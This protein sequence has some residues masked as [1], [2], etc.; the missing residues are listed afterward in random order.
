MRII[1]HGLVKG[2]LYGT[3][4]GQGLVGLR[5]AVCFKVYQTSFKVSRVWK[6]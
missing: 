4:G 3:L 5:I 1:L 2:L 6:I